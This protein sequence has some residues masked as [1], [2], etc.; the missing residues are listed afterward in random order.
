MIDAT[1]GRVEVDLQ[2]IDSRGFFCADLPKRKALF[3]YQLAV[4]WQQQEV[5]I[6]DAYRFGTLLQ[7]L[8]S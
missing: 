7:E 8:D 2:C 3:R 4:T 5:V 6:D 1:T